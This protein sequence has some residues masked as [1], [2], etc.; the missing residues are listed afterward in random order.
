MF[1][2]Y[3]EAL[4]PSSIEFA[5]VEEYNRFME[6]NLKILE[7][8]DSVDEAVKLE[9]GEDSVRLSLSEKY[10]EEVEKY[11]EEHGYVKLDPR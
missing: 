8:F 10:Q 2:L 1:I 7:N 3:I 4:A 11:H 5:S 9:V 6:A